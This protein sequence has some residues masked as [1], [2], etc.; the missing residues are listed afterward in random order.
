MIRTQGLWAA[1]TS[2]DA[3]WDCTFVQCCRMFT[4]ACII[5]CNRCIGRVT[6]TAY[7]EVTCSRAG[8]AQHGP[9]FAAEVKVIATIAARC[10][11]RGMHYSPRW[12]TVNGALGRS[13][14]SPW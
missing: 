9:S 14:T 12:C 2:G 4:H 3:A 7:A 10:S 13:C 6:I 11:P 1:D 5:D 8:C